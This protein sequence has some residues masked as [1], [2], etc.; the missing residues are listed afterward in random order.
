[1]LLD[2][3]LLS[4]GIDDVP[5]TA[6]ELEARGYA[7]IWASEVDHDPF[8][9]LHSAGT[10]TTRVTVGTAIAVAFARSPMTLALTAHDLQRAT[11]GRF[12]LG[13]GTQIKAH[14]ERR[15][16]MPWSSPAARMREYVGALRA[17]WAA[18]QDGT[19]LRFEGE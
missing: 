16:S 7:G 17:I 14:I 9:L 10:A 6:R 15:Y 3:A 18:W 5:A 11:R 19:P 1:M 13:L 4:T 8:L 12:V 2:A